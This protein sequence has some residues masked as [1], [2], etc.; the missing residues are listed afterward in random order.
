[1]PDIDAEGYAYGDQVRV[2]L[3]T[4][5]LT[6]DEWMAQHSG[7]DLND[8]A[9][10]FSQ[11]WTKVHE[12]PLLQVEHHTPAS[13]E[14]T[15]FLFV[16]NRVYTISLYP[17]PGG[18]GL[19]IFNT[20]VDSYSADLAHRAIS[21]TEL[22]ANCKKEVPASSDDSRIDLQ[23]KIVTFYWWDNTLQDN[24]SLTVPYE[25]EIGFA[26]CSESVKA[27]LRHI[28]EMEQSSIFPQ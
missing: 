9:L 8:T 22:A 23:I 18:E 7:F 11:V 28:Q 1:L 24:V 21:D 3:A 6:A 15:D 25:P 2:S 10:F 20:F 26:G 27:R 17:Y 13:D 19:G 5:T 14:L 16:G 4:T 12:H